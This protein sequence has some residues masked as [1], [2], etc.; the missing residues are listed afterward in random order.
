VVP[1]VAKEHSA[2][3]VKGQAVH[4]E[5]LLFILGCLT[6]EDEGTKLHCNIRNHLPITVS[7][8]RRL[9]SSETLVWEPKISDRF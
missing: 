5:Y 8:S 3:I 9:E 7:Y 1:G 4:R 6:L 2:F